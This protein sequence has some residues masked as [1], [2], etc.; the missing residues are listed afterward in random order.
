MRLASWPERGFSCVCVSQPP[1]STWIASTP[2]SALISAAADFR[3]RPNPVFG[4]A[5]PFD[6]TYPL[7]LIARSNPKVAVALSAADRAGSMS[8]NASVASQSVRALR[9]A[10]LPPMAKFPGS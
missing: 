4:Y 2:T 1:M 9:V 5:A 10:P 3:L 7:K 8:R 6:G